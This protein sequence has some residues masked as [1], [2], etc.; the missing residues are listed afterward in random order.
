MRIEDIA[1][2]ALAQLMPPPK[3]TVSQW[4]DAERMLSSEASAIPGR[5]RTELVEHMR[6]PMDCIGDP[7]IIRV[8]IMAAAQIAKS[9]VLLNV[10]GY[11]IDYDPS[12][13]MM[14]QPTL[15]MAEAFSKDRVAPMLRDTP[16]LRRKVADKNRDSSNTIR[17]KV[18][19]GGH[20][21]LVGA[22]SPSSLASRPIRAVLFDEVDRFPLS[23]GDEGDPVQLATKRTATF[24]NRIV[25]MV[26]TPTVK[27]ASRIE[28]AY[29]EGDQRVRFCPC[30]DCGHFQQLRWS[31]VK[32]TDRKPET[33]R[34]MC[35]ECG[36]LWT[37]TQRIIAVRKGYW[38][39]QAEFNG[40]ASFH[41]T[42]LLSPF[43]TMADGVREFLEATGDPGRLKVWVNTYLGETWEDAGER[44]DAHSLMERIE[45]YETQI[46]DGVTVLTAGIDVQDDR[47]EAEIIGWGDN[48][49]SWNIDYRVFYGDPSAPA[50]W[51]ELRLFLKQVYTHPRFGDM[52]MRAGCID[53]GGH[54]TSQTYQFI[55][56][57]DRVYGVKGMGGEGKPLVGKPSKNNYGGIVVFPVGT[58]TAKELVFARLRAKEGETGYCH[59]PKARNSEYFEQLTA[60]KL[61]TKY[62]KGF[63]RQEYIKI[64]SRNEALDVRVYG[65]AALDLLNVDLVA[66]RKAMES[67]WR[68]A[69]EEREKAEP[70]KQGIKPRSS[71]VN[72]WRNYD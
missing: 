26:S 56:Q 71:F 3:Y 67:R 25:V 68:K 52:S 28:D 15:E 18:F 11:L 47:I 53:T 43:A 21:T 35:S 66:Q 49:E 12:P 40:I 34:Y 50:I 29:E 55:S 13:I 44:L 10:I 42:G 59:F 6:E 41:V 69:T 57:M 46:P 27:G 7:R 5:W 60:E 22:N 38:E 14:V 9:E 45:D 54:Y 48:Y 70:Q 31:N 24:W 32:W 33:A 30:P 4:S 17:Q 23:A 63:K 20:L 8:V 37:D 16:A 61:V 65:T 58:H 64:R 2:E 36:S 62:T 72:S 51:S 19:P 1:K 39:A